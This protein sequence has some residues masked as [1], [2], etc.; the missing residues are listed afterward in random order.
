MSITAGAIIL[1]S[2][3]LGAV[4]GSVGTT[5]A[6]GGIFG[7][8]NDNTIVEQRSLKKNERKVIIEQNIN[9]SYTT[10]P[11]IYYDA[12]GQMHYYYK[13]NGCY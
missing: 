4:G 1:G 3:I 8:S 12:S 11:C 2:A 10:Y 9:P 13:E 5:M 7:D 6:T